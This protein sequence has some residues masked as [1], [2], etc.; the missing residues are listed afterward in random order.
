MIKYYIKK[1][2]LDGEIYNMIYVRKF[3]V[4]H[5]WVATYKSY[6]NAARRLNEIINNK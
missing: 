3:W 5:E 6:E 1:E 4:F 2:M